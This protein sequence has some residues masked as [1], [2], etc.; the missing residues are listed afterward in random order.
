MSGFP[1]WIRRDT[2][3]EPHTLSTARFWNGLTTPTDSPTRP[4]L[5]EN[6]QEQESRAESGASVVSFGR[7]RSGSGGSTGASVRGKVAS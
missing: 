7:S 1:R 2:T 4:L 6:L 3:Y 5:A